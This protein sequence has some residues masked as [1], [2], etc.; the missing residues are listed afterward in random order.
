MKISCKASDLTAAVKLVA[1]AVN[2]QSPLPILSC[3]KIET[4]EQKLLISATDLEVAI[5]CTVEAR[6][7]E[8]GSVAVPARLFAD[9]VATLPQG[10]VLISA[11]SNVLLVKCGAVKTTLKAQDV[12]EFPIVSRDPQDWQEIAMIEATHLKGMIKT[13]MHAAAKDKVRR[14]FTC[15]Y[16]HAQHAQGTLN[17]VAADSFRMSHTSLVFNEETPQTS[18]LIDVHA[19]NELV[20]VL[21]D[22]G[23]VYVYL[24]EDGNQVKFS[25]NNLEFACRLTSGDFP[26]Y[27]QI[28][29]IEP[30]CYVRAQT[31]ALVEAFK[32]AL[33]FVEADDHKTVAVHLVPSGSNLVDGTITVEAHGVDVGDYTRRVPAQIQ[34]PEPLSLRLNGKY[35]LDAL[36]AVQTE[37]V[38]LSA[39]SVNDAITFEPVGDDHTRHVIMPLHST[40]EVQAQEAVAQ[41]SAA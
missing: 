21:P 14:V 35:V 29:K 3:V 17:A 8:S 25:I 34:A 24:R 19:L 22:D 15:V 2:A 31:G 32:T 13:V 27:E 37:H 16:L 33:L 36:R 4:L 41:G 9:L 6:V 38:L 18:L 7:E 28:G 10:E 1:H 12:L 26:D 39:A 40:Q 23:L 5:D 30:T 11:S 20:S